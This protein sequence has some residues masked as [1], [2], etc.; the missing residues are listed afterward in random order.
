[1]VVGQAK[2]MNTSWA[3]VGPWANQGHSGESQVIICLK[4]PTAALPQ[5]P[6]DLK[7]ADPYMVPCIGSQHNPIEH[8]F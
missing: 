5:G 8:D 1:M 7:D 3:P 2:C 6:E 4:P